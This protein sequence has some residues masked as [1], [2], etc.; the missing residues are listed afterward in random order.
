[1]IDLTELSLDDYSSV[2]P[3]GQFDVGHAVD[4]VR[5]VCE[6]VRDQG[7][8]ALLRFS[9]QFDHVVPVSLRVPAQA[10]RDALDQIDPAVRAAIEVSIERR[11]TVCEQ[12]ETEPHYRNVELAPGAAVLVT[13]AVNVDPQGRPI[14]YSITR[15]AAERVEL[16]IDHER[17]GV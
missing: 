3:R 10:L 11:R 4:V 15:F 17:T 13:R 14:Q 6:A 5:P 9:E 12:T 8:D 7:Q 1:M 2:L 16:T